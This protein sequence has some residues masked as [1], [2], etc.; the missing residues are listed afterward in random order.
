[1]Q[2]IL[3]RSINKLSLQKYKI[4]KIDNFKSHKI[5]NLLSQPYKYSFIFNTED[6]IQLDIDDFNEFNKIYIRKLLKKKCILFI[7]YS[8]RKL[9]YTTWISVSNQTHKFIDSTSFKFLEKK[10]DFAVW[11]NAYTH[12]NFR[13]LGL[14]KF[15]LQES[16]NYLNSIG[17]N[18]TFSSVNY[19]NLFSIN[20]YTK[21]KSYFTYELKVIKILFLRLIFR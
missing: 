13:N 8:N 10:K 20:S 21:L 18:Y 3:T 17:L 15:A 16:I 14:N 5:N 2:I 11:G 4:F 7:I 6:L 19:K 1:M 12:N 9:I